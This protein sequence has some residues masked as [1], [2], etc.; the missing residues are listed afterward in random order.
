MAAT[1]MARPTSL[2]SLGGDVS[3][4]LL[5]LRRL[6]G[7]GNYHD[8]LEY[9]M[10]VW[11]GR[12]GRAASDDDVMT[13]RGECRW[14]CCCRAESEGIPGLKTHRSTGWGDHHTRHAIKK[15]RRRE[16]SGV[17]ELVWRV[18]VRQAESCGAGEGDHLFLQASTFYLQTSAGTCTALELVQRQP[19]SSRPSIHRPSLRR[20]PSTTHIHH[21]RSRPDTIE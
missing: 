9:G 5:G 8:Q 16:L 13:G 10:S 11:V 18:R 6:T 20:G 14:W 21:E 1:S 12:D 3:C 7:S 4:C 19:T 15:E 2:S 17:R